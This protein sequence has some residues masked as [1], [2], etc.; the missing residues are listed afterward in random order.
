MTVRTLATPLAVALLCL[1]VTR[2]GAQQG[3]VLEPGARIR[4]R[5]RNEATGYVGTLIA[6]HFDTFLVRRADSGQTLTVLGGYLHQLDVSRGTASRGRGAWKG[7]RI[8]LFLGLGAA[9]A[10]TLA[11]G[12]YWGAHNPLQPSPLASNNQNCI[13][14]AGV[15]AIVLG[16]TALG[17]FIG[18]RRPGEDW[19]NALPREPAP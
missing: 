3:P 11:T 10:A 6:A 8:G 17:A 13:G 14:L 12:C 1:P 16:G 15:S 2:D 18:S 4:W 5:L 9:L 19:V 7:G